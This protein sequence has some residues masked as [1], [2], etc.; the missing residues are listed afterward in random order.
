[1]EDRVHLL[2]F[3]PGAGD[4][5]LCASVRRQDYC[6]KDVEM[7]VNLV[8]G[9]ASLLEAQGMTNVPGTSLRRFLKEC[10]LHSGPCKGAKFRHDLHF[11]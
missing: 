9:G 5:V 7:A 11:T 4:S 3:V 8:H 2:Y 6:Q 10:T 1:M